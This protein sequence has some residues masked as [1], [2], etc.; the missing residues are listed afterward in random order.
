MA[1][2]PDRKEADTGPTANVR[3]WAAVAAILLPI[4]LLLGWLGGVF[5]EDRYSRGAVDDAGYRTNAD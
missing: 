3:K 2:E 1:R 5:D 4:L